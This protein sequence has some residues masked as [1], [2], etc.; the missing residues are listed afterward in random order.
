MLWFYYYF[1]KWGK[2]SPQ[3]SQ[4]RAEPGTRVFAVRSSWSLVIHAVVIEK[5]K[6]RAEV[7]FWHELVQLFHSAQKEIETRVIWMSSLKVIRLVSGRAEEKH[8]P[9]V[10][11]FPLF[12]SKQVPWHCL[13]VME[14]RS[15]E[16][17]QSTGC[18][19]SGE[20]CKHQERSITN[21]SLLV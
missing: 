10:M 16:S 18:L 4:D 15:L 1:Q 8:R 21:A 3:A 14:E 17:P 20:E 2:W 12:L 6:A 9:E 7:G 13:S 11:I 19:D 5:L